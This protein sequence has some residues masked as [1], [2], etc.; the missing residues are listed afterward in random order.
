MQAGK[1][2]LQARDTSSN[3]Y[4]SEIEFRFASVGGTTGATWLRIR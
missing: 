4:S 3:E 1:K 2:F